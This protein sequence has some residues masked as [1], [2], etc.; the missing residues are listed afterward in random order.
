MHKLRRRTIH[1]V[2]GRNQCVQIPTLIL[3]PSLQPEQLESDVWWHAGGHTGPAE[4]SR[5]RPDN[6]YFSNMQHVF[7][8]SHAGT[9]V[10]NNILMLHPCDPGMASSMHEIELHAKGTTFMELCFV[11]ATNAT[12]DMDWDITLS[13]PDADKAIAALQLEL[14]SLESTIL[15]RI[16]PYNEE[17]TVA[18]RLATPGRILLDIK[19]SGLYKARGV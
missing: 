15:T 2:T 19:R 13:G 11:L 12:K 3:P 17:F 7:N 18:K 6:G 4:T 9:S 5:P 1:C 10:I 8:I 14:D 16:H